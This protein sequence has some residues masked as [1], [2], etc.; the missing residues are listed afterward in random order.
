MY[1]NWDSL[2]YQPYMTRESAN[3]LFGY[4][5]HDI[6]G[7]MEPAGDELYLRWIQYG[8]FSPIFRTHG[9]RMAENKKKMWFYNPM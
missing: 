8:I 2:A 4:W 5:S 3:V 6:G 9:T 7:F 1:P